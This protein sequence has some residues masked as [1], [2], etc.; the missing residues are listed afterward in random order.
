MQSE[1]KTPKQRALRAL[2]LEQAA[3]YGR[4]KHT[5]PNRSEYWKW[6]VLRILSFHQRSFRIHSIQGALDFEQPTLVVTLST[7][8]GGDFNLS[9]LCAFMEVPGI[10]DEEVL[11]FRHHLESLL[12]VP[13]AFLKLS[14][15]PHQSEKAD[16]AELVVEIG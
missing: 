6:E 10:G 5:D 2:R 14:L 15:P 4:S 7:L 3:E 1:M 16:Q 9:T 12:P 11:R 8:P 13:L